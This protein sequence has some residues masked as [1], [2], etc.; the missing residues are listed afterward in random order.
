[1]TPVLAKLAGP[2][3]EVRGTRGVENRED[4]VLERERERERNKLIHYRSIKCL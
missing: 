2:Y 4:T 1:M 3:D